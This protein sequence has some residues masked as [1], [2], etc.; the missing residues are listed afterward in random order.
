LNAFDKD[1]ALDKIGAK[2]VA[3][4]PLFHN[5]GGIAF[6]VILVIIAIIIVG[7]LIKFCK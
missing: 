5:L 3:K 4:S 6:L 2:E 7:V 1:E